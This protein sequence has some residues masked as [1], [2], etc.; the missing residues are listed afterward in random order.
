MNTGDYLFGD[1]H[2]GNLKRMRTKAEG[3]AAFA[4]SVSRYAKATELDHVL[5]YLPKLIAE[6]EELLTHTEQIKQNLNDVREANE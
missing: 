2:Q 1:E 5:H 3:L 4:Q 6:Y